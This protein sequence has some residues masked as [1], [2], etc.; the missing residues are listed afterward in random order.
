MCVEG[1]LSLL[2][3]RLIH[4][5]QDRSP[6]PFKHTPEKTLKTIHHV[7]YEQLSR[8]VHHCLEIPYDAFLLECLLIRFE[9]LEPVKNQ[10]HQAY[11]LSFA[12]PCLCAAHLTHLQKNFYNTLS[13]YTHHHTKQTTPHT[14][15]SWLSCKKDALFLSL[16]YLY[17]LPLWFKDTTP[18][19]SPTLKAVKEIFDKLASIKAFST[20]TNLSIPL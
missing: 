8:H 16:I 2:F 7:M 3:N 11:R 5:L 10:A 4:A 17:V 15:P 1:R 18:D 20:L 9:T 13:F 6:T 12:H 14:M 19:F